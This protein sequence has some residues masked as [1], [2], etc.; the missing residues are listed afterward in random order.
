[1]TDKTQAL[2]TYHARYNNTTYQAVQTAILTDLDTDDLASEPAHGVLN[3]MIDVSLAACGYPGMD[4]RRDRL[5]AAV[6]HV[7]LSAD[8]VQTVA[9]HLA[10]FDATVAA[11]WKHT[12]LALQRIDTVNLAAIKSHTSAI[13]GAEGNAADHLMTAAANLLHLARLT[14]LNEPSASYQREKLSAAEW[15]LAAAKVWLNLD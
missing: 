13:H 12:V 15:S 3:L 10:N 5:A 9:A 14:L 2:Q 8:T 4:G 1:M 7:G 6:L 11:D